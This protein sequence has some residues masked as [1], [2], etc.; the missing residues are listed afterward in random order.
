MARRRVRERTLTRGQM[1]TGRDVEGHPR[2]GG[3]K[4]MKAVCGRCGVT[5]VLTPQGRRYT[6]TLNEG[7]MLRCAVI[8]EHARRQGGL[9]GE[10]DC[11]EIERA[12]YKE[13]ERW[14]HRRR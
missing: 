14:R 2:R 6:L 3:G 5:A 11:P 1:L 12:A 13:F 4:T 10:A 7:W 9:S 8:Q